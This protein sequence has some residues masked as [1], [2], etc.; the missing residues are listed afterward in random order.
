[1][2]FWRA[3]VWEL[4]DQYED[5]DLAPAIIAVLLNIPVIPLMTLR[6]ML[7]L[8][9]IGH[10]VPFL[11]LMPISVLGNVVG[12]LTPAAVGDLL[13]TPFFK[14]RHDIAYRDGLAAVVYERGFSLFVLAVSTGAAAAW[15]AL[16]ALAAV[17][18]TVACVALT[19]AG[20]P[21]GAL[22]LVRIRPRLAASGEPGPDASIWRK[23]WATV[24]ESADSLLVLLRDAVATGGTAVLSV[25]IFGIMAAQTWLVVD[26]LGLQLSAAEAWTALGAALLAGIVTF[27]PLGLGTFDAT[28]AAVVGAAEGGFSAGAAAAVLLRV[29]VTL[30]MGLAAF[31]SY[32][33]L[34]STGRRATAGEL[35]ATDATDRI[36]PD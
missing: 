7:V 15:M 8:R 24:G 20:P 11:A 18:V 36:L 26:A 5:F 23:A 9:R 4:N 16:P 12:S 3:R 35:D 30:P 22:V 28:F 2:V 13:R 31:A 34:V 21:I 14:D 32:V 27:L 17:A 33:Y 1:L 6:G 29:T 25:A 10:Q 19:V